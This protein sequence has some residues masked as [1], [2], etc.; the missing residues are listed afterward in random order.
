MKYALLKE[1]RRSI[2]LIGLML[3]LITSLSFGDTKI[4]FMH[5]QFLEPGKKEIMDELISKFE[6]ENPG[7]K[8]TKTPVPLA[9]IP[10]VLS[11]RI[12]GNNPP[13]ISVMSTIT[14]KAIALGWLEPLNDYIDFSSVKGMLCSAWDEEAKG[15]DGKYYVFV[16]ENMPH[17]MFYNKRLFAEA[18]L[19]VPTT[20]EEFFDAAKKLTK[21]NQQYGYFIV[22]NPAET[23]RMFMDISRWVYAYDGRWSRNNVLT[24]NEPN[25]IKAV[26]MYKKIYDSKVVPWGTDKG[27]SRELFWN[28][29]IAMAFEGPYFYEWIRA[30]NPSLLSD[31]GTAP[32]PFPS[33]LCAAENLYLGIPKN[34]PNK[35]AAMKFL[36]FLIRKDIQQWYIEKT[37]IEGAL[38]GMASTA[39]LNA[40]PWYKPF[41]GA[42]TRSTTIEGFSEYQ[43][44]ISQIV[45][46]QLGQV[47]Y[48][49]KSAKTAMDDAQKEAL[50]LVSRQ[51]K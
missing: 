17:Q 40:N 13:D 4:E 38:T 24:L 2:R 31:I 12:A 37:C 20:I 35:Q 41:I 42:K 51:N 44:E 45:T 21:G 27:T 16:Q 5:Y 3:I 1:E 10:K 8:V 29:K 39:F 23:G 22:T 25:V 36:N 9:D 11:T 6:S 34:A 19:N 18:G 48:N 32:V 50:E 28:G 14:S 15:P 49:N 46:N 47:L 43:T 33:H 30:N 26:E 7:I